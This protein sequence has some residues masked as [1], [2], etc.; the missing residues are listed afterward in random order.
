VIITD[1]ILKRIE[2]ESEYAKKLAKLM[3]TLNL[4]EGEEPGYVQIAL[5]YIN[6]K[7]T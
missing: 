1:E 2:M 4:I 6:I 3:K 5:L 7:S